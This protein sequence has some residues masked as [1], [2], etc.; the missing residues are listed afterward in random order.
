MRSAEGGDKVG[1]EWR[2]YFH[3]PRCGGK[4]L[5]NPLARNGTEEAVILVVV[6]GVALFGPLIGESPNLWAY[7]AGALLV[8]VFLMYREYQKCRDS[9]HWK[10]W[11]PGK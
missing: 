11:L 1:E 8:A 2:P 4:L 3:C 10:R 6:V 7:R 5:A 9:R